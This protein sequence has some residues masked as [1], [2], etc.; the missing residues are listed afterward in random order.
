MA[1]WWTF[2]VQEC[3]GTAYR[4]CAPWCPKDVWERFDGVWLGPSSAAPAGSWTPPA[5]LPEPFDVDR[6]HET[7]G[8]NCGSIALAM[9]AA[10]S[11]QDV[12]TAFGNNWPGYTNQTFMTAVFAK[13]G[14]TVV[15]RSRPAPE[16][17]SRSHGLAFVQWKSDR[18]GG[19]WGSARAAY[20]HTHWIAVAEGCVFDVNLAA[21]VPWAV[22]KTAVPPMLYHPH[23]YD[24]RLFL[25]LRKDS[26]ICTA[27]STT[28]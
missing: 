16:E 7:W 10:L 1:D 21:W 3:G 5:G 8:A 27:K 26:C 22:W 6:A 17:V 24:F 2:H 4:G 11:I 28:P 23:G 14:L 13:L 12:M 9:C 20:L 15:C 18:P 25:H 19:G